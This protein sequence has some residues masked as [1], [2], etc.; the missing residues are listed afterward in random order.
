MVCHRILRNMQPVTKCKNYTSLIPQ[1]TNWP[2]LR[3]TCENEQEREPTGHDQ[4]TG[5]NLSHVCIKQLCSV[6]MCSTPSI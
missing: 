6:Y 4:V 3:E 2:Q 5:E 1:I